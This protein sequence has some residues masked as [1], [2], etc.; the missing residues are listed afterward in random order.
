LDKSGLSAGSLIDR[1][2]SGWM[3]GHTNKTPPPCTDSA[4]VNRWCRAQN[5]AGPGVGLAPVY[6]IRIII[7]GATFKNLIK[8]GTV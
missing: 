3:G 6:I 4:P 7:D 5:V 2:P 8:I 1:M